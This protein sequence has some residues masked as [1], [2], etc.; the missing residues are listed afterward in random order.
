[1]IS[2]KKTNKTQADAFVETRAA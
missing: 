1:M 2:R